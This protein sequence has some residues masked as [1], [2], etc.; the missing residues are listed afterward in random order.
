MLVIIAFIHCYLDNFDTAER[1]SIS[2]R[3]ELV[4]VNFSKCRMSQFCG[5]SNLDSQSSFYLLLCLV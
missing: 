2:E 5:I 1:R 4:F 3:L